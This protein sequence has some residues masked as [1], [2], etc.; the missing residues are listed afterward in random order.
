M[1]SLV[2]ESEP[3]FCLQAAVIGHEGG[4]RLKHFLWVTG[5]TVKRMSGDR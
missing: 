2:E 3:A 1:E 4:V 5:E